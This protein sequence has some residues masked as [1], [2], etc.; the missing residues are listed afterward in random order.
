MITD[1]NGN[2]YIEAPEVPV[3][4]VI[5]YIVKDYRRMYYYTQKLEKENE[6]LRNSLQRVNKLQYAQQRIIKALKEA[7]NHF[8]K[9]MRKNGIAPSSYV[10]N[11]VIPL[12]ENRR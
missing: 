8:L 2:N 1:E 10:T 4:R 9:V 3:E 6:R 5:H 12:L 7:I 11:D